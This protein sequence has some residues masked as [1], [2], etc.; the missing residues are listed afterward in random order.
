M[1]GWPFDPEMLLDE[2]R[3]FAIDSLGKF[4]SFR[5]GSFLQLQPAHLFF[6]WR[7]DEHMER[8]RA[9]AQI[10]RRT[11]PNDH[12]MAFGGRRSDEFFGQVANALSIRDFHPGLI[13]AAFEAAPQ[14][15][16]EE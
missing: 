8:V 2:G 7:I 4:N 11:A 1:P 6:K 3:A 14:E 9:I 13:E 12:R 5:L 15:S 16:L 10:I